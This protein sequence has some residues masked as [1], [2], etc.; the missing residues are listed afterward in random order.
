MFGVQ[1]SLETKKEFERHK[2]AAPEGAAAPEGCELP[3]AE[4]APAPASAPASAPL[5][6]VPEDA[7]LLGGLCVQTMVP[8]VTIAALSSKIN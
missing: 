1:A 4:T 7:M 6:A 3:A 5:P 8:Q 2:C